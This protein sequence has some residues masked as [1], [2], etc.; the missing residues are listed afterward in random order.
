MVV[1]TKNGNGAGTAVVVAPSPGAKPVSFADV[2]DRLEVFERLAESLGK[3]GKA[4]SL[5]TKESVLAVVVAGAELGV[6]PMAAINGLHAIEGKLSMSAQ[7][8]HSLVN[9]DLPGS[10]FKITESFDAKTNDGY[11][12]VTLTVPG[13]EPYTGR[14]TM[15]DA[16]RA[17]LVKSG[18]NWEKSPGDML[19]SKA[20]L[21][22]IRRVAPEVLN[23]MYGTG[24]LGEA[25]ETAS[26]RPESIDVPVV[27]TRGG[28]D[29]ALTAPPPAAAAPAPIEDVVDVQPV[30]ETPA[31]PPASA[32]VTPA[33]PVQPAGPKPGTVHTAQLTELKR[34]KDKLALSNDDWLRTLAPHGVKSAKDL[35]VG[36][37]DEL[38]GELRRKEVSGPK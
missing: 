17:G 27:E 12:E 14:Y 8:A 18:S 30:A 22:A 13:R 25:D 31:P 36:Q 9:R 28:V 7:L 26:A 1:A 24:E 38:I 19:Y 33:A 35:S 37:A 11:C 21:R 10:K 4:G 15:A 16:K 23:G 6:P 29:P 2:I 20:L 5:R 34:L 3:S 32:P